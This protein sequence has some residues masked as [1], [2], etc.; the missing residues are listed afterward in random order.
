MVWLLVLGQVSASTVYYGPG[1]VFRVE[2]PEGWVAEEKPTP[3][4]LAVLAKAGSLAKLSVERIARDPK[5]KKAPLVLVMDELKR[6]TPNVRVSRP[7]VFKSL[8][9]AEMLV[10]EVWSGEE[11]RVRIA[12]YQTAKQA[13]IFRLEAP[14]VESYRSG[15]SAFL[16]LINSFGMVTEKKKG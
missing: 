3:P 16:S 1:Y 12:G 10:L 13:I 15:T 9:D 5:E 4:K 6:V 14:S 2:I 8:T 11:P 7:V